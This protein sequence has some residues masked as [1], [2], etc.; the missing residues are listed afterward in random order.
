MLSYTGEVKIADFGIAKAKKH[1]EITN[2]GVLKGKYRY[3]SP[4]QAHGAN[5][6]HRSDIFAVGILLYELL[7]GQRL[8]TADNDKEL[9][10]AVKTCEIVEPRKHNASISPRL[11]K[12]ICRALHR[13]P[14]MR[15]QSAKD[16]QE[17]LS[18]EMHPQTVSSL[19]R[20]L[21]QVMNELFVSDKKR[22]RLRRKTNRDIA[23][24]EH[25]AP[26]EDLDMELGDILEDSTIDGPMLSTTTDV[27]LEDKLRLI[28][29]QLEKEKLQKLLFIGT[30]IA[31]IVY[32]LLTHS[33]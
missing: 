31:L 19:S 18:E 10:D 20:Q 29:E 12:I 25:N 3:M 1:A 13:N 4:E 16:L 11:N 8:F 7:T 17:A 32:T 2:S 28:Q 24:E 26:V 33:I 15:Y 27:F 23:W 30:T 14:N 22:D 9:L 21:T 5:I 6:D